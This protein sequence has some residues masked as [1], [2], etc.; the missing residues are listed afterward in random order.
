V[1]PGDLIKEGET[2]VGLVEW[3][4]RR[5]GKTVRTGMAESNTKPE[6]GVRREIISQSDNY[7]DRGRKIVRLKR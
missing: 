6:W 2:H 4:E 5:K 1:L 7:L 3:V